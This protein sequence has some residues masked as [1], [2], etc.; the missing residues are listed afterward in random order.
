M[1]RR[2][3]CF[4]SQDWVDADVGQSVAT[5]CLRR[6]MPIHLGIFLRI[7]LHDLVKYAIVIVQLDCIAYGKDEDSNERI[8]CFLMQ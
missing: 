5:L 4:F 8:L 7:R 6:V 3:A 2:H 1:S